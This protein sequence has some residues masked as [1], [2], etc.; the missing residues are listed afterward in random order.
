MSTS[1]AEHMLII[2]NETVSIEPLKKQSEIDVPIERLRFTSDVNDQQV[3]EFS[4][5]VTFLV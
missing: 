1:Y 3:P 4:P 2:H 5:K